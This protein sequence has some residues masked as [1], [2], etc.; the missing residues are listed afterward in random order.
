MKSFTYRKRIS[1]LLNAPMFAIVTFLL[2]HATECLQIGYT[3]GRVAVVSKTAARSASVPP[4]Q[5]PAHI[6]KSRT[7]FMQVDDSNT[8]DGIN[9]VVAK[10]G[11]QEAERLRQK[12]KELMNEAISAE[13]DLRSSKQQADKLKNA[14]LDEIFDDLTSGILTDVVVE[15]GER[16]CTSESE[17]NRQLMNKLREK[18]LSSTKMIQLIER[19]HKRS[20]ATEKKIMAVSANTNGQEIENGFNI[21]DM[22]NSRKYMETELQMLQWNI[23]RIIDAQGLLDAERTERAV[24]GEDKGLASILEARLREL[25]RAEE[26]AFQ[27]KLAMK[28]NAGR[29]IKTGVREFVQETMGDQNV[30]IKIDGKEFSGSKVNMT[31]LMDDIVQVPMWVP[32]SILPFLIVCRKDLDPADLKRLRAEVLN[33]SQFKVE[34]SDF[35]RMA[36]FYRGSFVQKRR[37]ALY[38][39]APIAPSGTPL[40]SE[41][42]VQTQGFLSEAVFGEVQDRLKDAGLADKIQLFLMED[43]EWRPGDRD[44]EPLPSIL[45][46]S[47]EVVPEQGSERRNGMNL[48]A[49]STLHVSYMPKKA[50]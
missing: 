43:P 6:N 2:S 15:E 40:G 3:G 7:L 11:M 34:N 26:E 27:R 30:T 35:T 12:A 39:A 25:R 18:R 33:G 46:V 8:N 17:L 23:D 45:A 47:S 22:S 19:L 29:T 4:H 38:G 10:S 49:V 13:N 50:L 21:G 36:G 1:P 48:A 5:M 41:K 31:R 24:R 44:P 9:A 20:I 14:A 32:S 16:D 28:V 37:A 42:I